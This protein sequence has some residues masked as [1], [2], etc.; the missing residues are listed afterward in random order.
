MEELK[1]AG[2]SARVKFESSEG[3]Y[4]CTYFARTV[5]TQIKKH[6][7]LDTRKQ[8]WS[9]TNISQSQGRGGGGESSS[10]VFHLSLLT[11]SVCQ[12]DVT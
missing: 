12:Y 3:K 2:N 4:I 10:I 11:H 5:E 8:V 7:I 9:S 1:I 6:V